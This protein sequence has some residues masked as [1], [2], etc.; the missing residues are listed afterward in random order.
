[1]TSPLSTLVSVGSI[2][3]LAANQLFGD[4]LTVAGI[5]F[6]D[7]APPD[8]MPGGGDQAM[9]GHKL[10]GGQRVIDILGPDEAD[11]TWSGKFT[12]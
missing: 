3:S 4:V 11:V 10:P 12:L 9:V 1:M 2:A 5:P 8:A 6:T 7:F